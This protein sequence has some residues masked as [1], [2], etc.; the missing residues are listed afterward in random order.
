MKLFDGLYPHELEL[1][2]P[3][4]A[5]FRVLSMILTRLSERE[6]APRDR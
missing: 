3:G 5:M 4:A 2:V 6:S 1:P